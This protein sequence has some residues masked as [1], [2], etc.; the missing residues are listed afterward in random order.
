MQNNKA[1]WE[2]KLECYNLLHFGKPLH[3]LNMFLNDRAKQ[4]SIIIALISP[5]FFLFV[6]NIVLSLHQHLVW[7]L[8]YAFD[9]LVS[10]LSEKIFVTMKQCKNHKLIKVVYFCLPLPALLLRS[11]MDY[12]N[13][14]LMILWIPHLTQSF[15]DSYFLQ[16]E[17]TAENGVLFTKICEENIIIGPI[18]WIRIQM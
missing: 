6:L 9:K 18:P 5:W 7:F 11:F 8:L 3:L 17:E 13:L 12:R 1:K 14:F 15:S 10:I 4:Q 16:W 2:Y